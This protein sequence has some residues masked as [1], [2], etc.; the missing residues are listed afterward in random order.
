[1]E[2]FGKQYDDDAI[3]PVFKEPRTARE[4]AEMARQAYGDGSDSWEWLHFLEHCDK[5]TI[6]KDCPAHG[7]LCRDAG[8]SARDNY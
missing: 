2:K 8:C 7:D 6:E 3:V 5:F 4:L 1:M